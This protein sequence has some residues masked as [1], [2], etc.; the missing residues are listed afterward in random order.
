[1][2]FWPRGA[3]LLLS[4][5]VCIMKPPM[6]GMLGCCWGAC[7]GELG[8][9][10]SW[11]M[12]GA[13]PALGERGASRLS[14]SMLMAPVVSAHVAP[15]LLAPLLA[16]AGPAAGCGAP[17]IGCRRPTGVGCRPVIGIHIMFHVFL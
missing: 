7:A 16:G 12:E 6:G 9:D 13:G 1:M 10:L 3:K 14:T 15:S 17:D 4:R 11:L 2:L 5:L 8:L